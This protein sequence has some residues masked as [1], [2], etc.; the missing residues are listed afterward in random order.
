M[1]HSFLNSF[2][3]VSYVYMKNIFLKN[4]NDAVQVQNLHLNLGKIKLYLWSI[5]KYFIFIAYLTIHPLLSLKIEN[6][7]VYV[8]VFFAWVFELLLHWLSLRL[9]KHME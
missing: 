4:R 8:N 3:L 2:F 1:V 5:M 9:E 7:P 6:F